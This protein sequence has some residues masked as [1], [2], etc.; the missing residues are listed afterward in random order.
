MAYIE[1][2]MMAENAGAGAKRLAILSLS[3]ALVVLLVFLLPASRWTVFSTV[4]LAVVLC[5]IIAYMYFRMDPYAWKR[6][7]D[8]PGYE[9]LR[10]LD[11]RVIESLRSLDDSCLVLVN[12]TVELFHIEYLV[13][14]RKGVYLLS[15]IEGTGM[16][17]CEN[18]I[19]RVGE[20]SLEKEVA[21]LWRTCHFLGILMK[22]TY[23][24]DVL[25]HPVLVSS[26]TGAFIMD[27]CAEITITSCESIPSVITRASGP[28][29][30]EG[31]AE[32]FAYFIKTRYMS[33]G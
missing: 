23:Q 32:N 9:R 1:G 14:S 20:H 33:A 24:V 22:K 4:T 29:L 13:V 19:P 28:P 5:L 6:I 30:P 11:R 12:T 7:F 21:L 8:R 16:T 27:N 15:K 17:G 10:E 25:P 3:G 2:K 26:D 18:G 31:A